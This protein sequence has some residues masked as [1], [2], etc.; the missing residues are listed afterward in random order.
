LIAQ[1]ALETGWGRHQ[2]RFADGRPSN[3]LFNIKADS[4]WE[5]ERVAVNTVEYEQG[6]AVRKREYFRAYPSIRQGFNDYVAVLQAKPRYGQALA[7]ARRPEA[8][9]AALQ[10]AGYATDPRYA[11]K[12]VAVLRG[13][14]M[15]A[16]IAQIKDASGRP[17]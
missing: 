15:T 9:F 13:T 7:A 14:E 10:E 2:I 1:A 16:A 17:L 3:N 4:R 12:V 6:V 8:Y 11:D 5:G